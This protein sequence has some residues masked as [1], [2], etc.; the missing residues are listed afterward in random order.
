MLACVTCGADFVAGC[1]MSFMLACVTC[2]ADFVAGCDVS[3]MLTCL[4]CG[5]DSHS[6]HRFTAPSSKLCQI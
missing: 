5:A 2:G 4:T 6:E 3:F 1:D